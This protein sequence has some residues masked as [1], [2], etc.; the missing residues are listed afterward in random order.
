M[1]RPYITC[2]QLIDFIADYVA[3]DLDDVE[4]EDFDRHLGVCP[5]CRAYLDSYRKTMALACPDEPL[6]D[7]PEALVQRILGRDL[8]TRLKRG[9]AQAFEELVRRYSAQLL[10]AA[11]RLLASEEDA[12]D[13]VQDAFVNAFR[14]MRDFE[15][16]AKIST[17]L[18]R[19]VIN[20]SLMRL[21]TR[22]RKP[23]EEIEQYLPR[24]LEDGH[25]TESSAPWQE[26]A[27]AMLEREELRRLVRETI[28]RLPES[29]RVVLIL[30]DLEELSTEET[31]AML[32]A[33]ANA[34]KIRLHRA[35]Q[36]LRTM[37][38]PYVRSYG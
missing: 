17:W 9:D 18:H 2:R 35:R 14:S 3:G 1:A 10:R 25:Q 22:R 16:S 23:E 6:P 19:I 36:A 28:E 29:Y 13:A 4:R 31:A 20:A 26:P 12:R 34:V 27:D 37:L 30:R 24:F 38:D 7:V 32:G 5:S 15:A 8:V 21:R 11:R 33:T